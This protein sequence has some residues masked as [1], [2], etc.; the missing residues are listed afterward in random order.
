[1]IVM[2]VIYKIKNWHNLFVLLKQQDCTNVGDLKVYYESL[3]M[4][5]FKRIFYEVGK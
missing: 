5:F 2:Y 4:I 3:S 1:M